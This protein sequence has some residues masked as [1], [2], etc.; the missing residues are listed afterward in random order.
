M[1]LAALMSSAEAD[2]FVLG[3]Q[4]ISNQCKCT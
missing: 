1:G 4:G 3:A 2:K